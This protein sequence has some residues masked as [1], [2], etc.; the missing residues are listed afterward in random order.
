MKL[1]KL[2]VVELWRCLLLTWK[3][4]R[5]RFARVSRYAE[6]CYKACELVNEFRN[7]HPGE[8]LFW[9]FSTNHVID[10]AQEYVAVW[11]MAE[12]DRKRALAVLVFHGPREAMRELVLAGHFDPVFLKKIVMKEVTDAEDLKD[13]EQDR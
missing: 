12:I 3:Y 11:R 5:F 8:R 9:S 7:R 4:R 6:A 1:L 10:S 2:V 13:D